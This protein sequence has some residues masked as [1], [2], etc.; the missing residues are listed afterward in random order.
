M[1]G[2]IR[3]IGAGLRARRAAPEDDLA[4]LLC[5]YA[6]VMDTADGIERLR[7]LVALE[8]WCEGLC[9]HRGWDYPP[10]LPR[11]GRVEWGPV[12]RWKTCH[13]TQ[14]ERTP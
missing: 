9:Y 1:R 13:P 7:R 8:A 5:Y 11:D 3:R 6:A 2:L 12:P 14:A 4:D 10:R